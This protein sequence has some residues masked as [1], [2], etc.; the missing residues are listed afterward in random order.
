[1]SIHS[2]G[3]VAVEAIGGS[4]VLLHTWRYPVVPFPP[5]NRSPTRCARSSDLPPVTARVVS[6]WNLTDM[7]CDRG[8]AGFGQVGS[9]ARLGRVNK[10]DRFGIG[11]VNDHNFSQSGDEMGKWKRRG[12]SCLFWS[13]ATNLISPAVGEIREPRATTE[14]PL[15][16]LHSLYTYV[17]SHDSYV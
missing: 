13:P 2:S 8:G 11:I 14:A 10:G 6:S 15:K 16:H 12:G 9:N 17:K 5:V 7:M 3:S 4:L 1:V